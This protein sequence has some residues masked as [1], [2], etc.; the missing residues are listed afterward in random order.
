MQEFEAFVEVLIDEYTAVEQA[1]LI[2]ESDRCNRLAWS[3][4][5]NRLMQA[6]KTLRPY[7]NLRTGTKSRCCK[8]PLGK[9]VCLY[10]DQCS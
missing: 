6:E 7:A 10:A 4:E 2:D 5:R 9:S 3:E 8:V 1:I